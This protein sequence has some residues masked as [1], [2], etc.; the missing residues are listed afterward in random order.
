MAD[1]ASPGP[2]AGGR[3]RRPAFGLEF[4][5]LVVICLLGLLVALLILPQR[6]EPYLQTRMVEENLHQ[7]VAGLE[8]RQQEY[9]A[10]IY[11]VENDS[12]YRDEVYRHV[13]G[14]QKKAE[15]VLKLPAPISD[16]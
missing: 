8:L 13:L 14:V 11:A 7:T 10:A 3:E 16:N 1:R 5:N 6:L 15:K 12:F 9:E 4:F 2:D